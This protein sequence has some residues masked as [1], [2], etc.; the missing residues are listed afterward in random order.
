[1]KIKK[2]EKCGCEL[3]SD[4]KYKLCKSCSTRKK[5][6]VKK[7]AAIAGG[8]LGAVLAIIGSVFGIKGMIKKP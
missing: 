3:P 7:D 5:E 8:I 6:K 2:C 1:M 4:S